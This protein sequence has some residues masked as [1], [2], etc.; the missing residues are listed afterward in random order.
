MSR[1]CSSTSVK[2]VGSNAKKRLMRSKTKGNEFSVMDV[3]VLV[4]SYQNVLH[5]SRNRKMGFCLLV[6]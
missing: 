2:T 1:T 5:T 3:K 4:T 6:R